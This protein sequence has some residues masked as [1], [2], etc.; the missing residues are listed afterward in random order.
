MAFTLRMPA[1]EAQNRVS[2]WYAAKYSRKECS[3]PL[4]VCY[5]PLMLRTYLSFLEAAV[6]YAFLAI[7]QLDFITLPSVES[8]RTQIITNGCCAMPLSICHS[9]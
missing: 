4:V 9:I 2:E 7:C 3:I 5:D 6:S 8:L 1:S